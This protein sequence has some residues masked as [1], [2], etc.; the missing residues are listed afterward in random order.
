MKTIRLKVL[1][2]DYLNKWITE[3]LVN[4]FAGNYELEFCEDPDYVFYPA[5]D[6]NSAPN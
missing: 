2:N 1:F 6:V 5:H 3:N 4:R